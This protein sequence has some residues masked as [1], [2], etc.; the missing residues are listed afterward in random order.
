MQII[1][2][3]NFTL[4]QNAKEAAGFDRYTTYCSARIRL[5][6][7]VKSLTAIFHD[8]FLITFYTLNWD[9]LHRACRLLYLSMCKCRRST[10]L[11]VSN[12]TPVPLQDDVVKI[13][14]SFKP[15]DAEHGLLK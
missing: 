5:L 12:R 2:G 13:H 1:M 3:F 10:I 4:K 14:S 9:F 11:N 7:F 6:R 15:T 8:S